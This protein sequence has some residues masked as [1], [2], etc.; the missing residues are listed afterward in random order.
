MFCF[1]FFLIIMSVSLFVSL[2]F[3]R[4]FGDAPDQFFFR[5]MARSF[6]A[7]CIHPLE[8]YSPP[9][10]FSNL[11]TPNTSTKESCELRESVRKKK[12]IVDDPFRSTPPFLILSLHTHARPYTV[13]CKSHSCPIGLP[14]SIFISQILFHMYVLSK[15]RIK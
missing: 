1:A 14:F 11:S 10:S 8:H 12:T 13:K 5:P 15:E 2:T 6:S 9:P 7:F 3:P 4:V